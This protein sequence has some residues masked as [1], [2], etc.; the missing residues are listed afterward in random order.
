MQTIH[1]SR[2][3]DTDA[4]TIFDVIADHEGYAS[5]PGVR[6]AWLRVP[7]ENERGGIGAERVIKLPAMQLVEQIVE[8]QPGESLGYRIIE[9]PLP[10]HHLGA[11]ILL[12]P[13]GTSGLRTRVHWTS[14]L[15]GTTPIAADFAALAVAKQMQLAYRGALE[16]WARRLG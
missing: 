2:D 8:Y 1:V 13:L 5:L 9:S 14:R 11:R 7:G 10:I 15:R 12:Q 6:A 3:F 4:A 16:V